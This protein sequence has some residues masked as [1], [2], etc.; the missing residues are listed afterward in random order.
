MAKYIKKSEKNGNFGKGKKVFD[1]KL[2]LL[3]K[4]TKLKKVFIPFL[5]LSILIIF[6]KFL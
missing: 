2:L 3:Y 5:V 6:Y 4:F 1:I